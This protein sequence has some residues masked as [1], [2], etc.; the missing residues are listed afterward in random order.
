M[1]SDRLALGTEDVAPGGASG[2]G[3]GSRGTLDLDHAAAGQVVQVPADGGGR[4]AQQVAEFGG[5]DGPVF[6]H[7]VQDAVPGAL[8][9]VSAGAHR[10]AG[11]P[12]AHAP[13]RQRRAVRTRAGKRGRVEVLMEYTTQSCRNLLPRASKAWLTSMPGRGPVR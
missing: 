8:V 5:A 6:Q 10:G 3:A 11:F 4:E 13:G 1:P 9:R 7:G 12:A 2:A